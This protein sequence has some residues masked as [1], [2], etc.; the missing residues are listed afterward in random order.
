MKIVA[1]L[2]AFAASAGTALAAQPT[3][4]VAPASIH[5]GGMVEVRGN[6]GDCPVGDSVTIISRAFAGT[7]EFAGVPAVFAKVQAEGVFRVTARIPRGRA[8]GRYVITA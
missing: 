5:P 2:A 6:A 1:L 3:L 7:H 4:I 8:A